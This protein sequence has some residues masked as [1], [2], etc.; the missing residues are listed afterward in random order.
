MTFTNNFFKN[1]WGKFSLPVFFILLISC[2]TYAQI[3]KSNESAINKIKSTASKTFIEE[4]IVGYWLFD[5]LS[6]PVGESIKKREIVVDTLKV[7]EQVSRPDIVFE[8]TKKYKII[9]N[10]LVIEKGVWSYNTKDKILQF[11]FDK[12]KYNVPI[13]KVSPELL[14]KLKK[15]GALIEFKENSWEIHKIDDES[16]SIIE[17]LTHNEFEL[18]YNLRVYKKRK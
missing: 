6:N 9:N 12:P 10:G 4:N 17:H 11:V 1:G 5:K 18:K 16:L 7:L 15:Q 14:E 8:K 3:E 2:K 13:N